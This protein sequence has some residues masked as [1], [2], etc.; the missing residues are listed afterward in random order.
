VRDYALSMREAWGKNIIRAAQRWQDDVSAARMAG[1]KVGAK[2]LEIRY[3]DLLVKPQP[4]LEFIT[5]FLGID[6][7]PEM[8]RPERIVEN[9]GAAKQTSGIL[10]S[11]VQK[12]LTQ[13]PAHQVAKLEMI[14]GPTLRE[15]G[16]P[17]VYLGEAVRVPS[18]RMWLLQLKDGWNIIHADITRLGLVRSIRYN[19]KYFRI[20]GNRM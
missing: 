9:K 16:Y 20:S 2:Y 13:M 10:Q 19:F 8:L 4:T 15:L 17:C 11:N 3:E 7:V 18:W 1:R 6:F 5:S 14:A 12:Y